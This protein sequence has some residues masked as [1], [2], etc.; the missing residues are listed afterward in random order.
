[1]NDTRQT[2]TAHTPGPWLR[3]S[4]GDI[5]AP[6]HHTI[7][8]TVHAL[9]PEHK[10]NA[11]LIA[12]APDLLAALEALW[13]TGPVDGDYFSATAWSKARAAIRAARGEAS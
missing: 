4:D 1:M 5:V 2:T 9:L 10:G 12:S 6:G 13:Q 8:A 3:L 11:R 7:I